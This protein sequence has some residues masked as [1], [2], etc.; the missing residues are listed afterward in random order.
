LE[1]KAHVD[2]LLQEGA[3]KVDSMI[4]AGE[5]PFEF[6]EVERN[7]RAGGAKWVAARRDGPQLY[8]AG[9]M[10]MNS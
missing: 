9:G 5:N 6:R 4:A 7:D 10:M 2:L 1:T 3:T 8:F